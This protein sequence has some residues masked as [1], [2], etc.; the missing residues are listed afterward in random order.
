MSVGFFQKTFFKFH[1]RL[2]VVGRFNARRRFEG[3]RED[4]RAC[5]ASP[6]DTPSGE[7]HYFLECSKLNPGFLGGR[8]EKPQTAKVAE[9][10]QKLAARKCLDRFP[11]LVNFSINSSVPAFRYVAREVRVEV[12]WGLR[13]LYV[14]NVRIARDLKPGISEE[15]L[16][17]VPSPRQNVQVGV[18]AIVGLTEL[19][20]QESNATSDGVGPEAPTS[21]RREGRIET[22]ELVG[23]WSVVVLQCQCDEA[24]R[25]VLQLGSQVGDDQ[26]GSVLHAGETE[27][28]MATL[29]SDLVARG[30]LRGLKD[31]RAS[32]ALIES[33]GTTGGVGDRVDVGEVGVVKQVDPGKAVGV[34]GGESLTDAVAVG[35]PGS[36]AK[37]DASPGVGVARATL[38]EG[39]QGETWVNRVRGGLPGRRAVLIRNEME[40]PS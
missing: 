1:I 25:F 29:T 28:I 23:E 37:A 36:V 39:L 10:R 19:Q 30:V 40:A 11:Q 5:C 17:Y 33:T 15:V 18:P 3:G 26:A 31:D 9:G 38:R 14:D 27:S 24:R 8:L 22:V 32:A 6:S 20:F 13:H 12:V 35:V 4:G 2:S 21:E 7:T 34:V 16:R